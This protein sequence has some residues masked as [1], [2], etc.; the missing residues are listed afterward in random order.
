MEATSQVGNFAICF[1]PVSKLVLP[2]ARRGGAKGI[3]T[4]P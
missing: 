3:A 2:S 4:G 1:Q